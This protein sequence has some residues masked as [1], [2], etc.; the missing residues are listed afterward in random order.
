MYS[1][2]EYLADRFSLAFLVKNISYTNEGLDAR[3]QRAVI[4]KQLEI[5]PYWIVYWL[6]PFSDQTAMWFSG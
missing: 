2:S 5:P 3:Q 1:C 4:K 6:G